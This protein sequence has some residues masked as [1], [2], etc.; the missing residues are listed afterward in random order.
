MAANSTSQFEEYE[1]SD[2]ERKIFYLASGPKDGPLMIFVHGWPGIA[3][4]WHPQLTTFA[5]LGFRVVA[6]DMRGYGRS[7][8]SK[9]ANDYR[10]ELIVAD[11]RALLG[12]L[13][14]DEAVWIGH[15]WG[16][17]VVWALV[18]HHPEVSSVLQTDNIESK[19][20]L[21]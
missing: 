14:R 3:E 16:C 6:P 5:A 12:H 2:A 18:A 4:T 11:M 7:T 13:Q 20:V 1:F 17:G 19:S 8:V 15:D 21:I 10:L 9:D